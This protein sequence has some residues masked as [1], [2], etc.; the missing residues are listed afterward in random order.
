MFDSDVDAF[1]G[2]YILLNSGSSVTS[3][4]GNI[5]FGGGADPSVEY[6]IGTSNGDPGI[7]LDRATVSAGAGN[8]VMNGKGNPA[9]GEGIYLYGNDDAG[10]ANAAFAKIITNSGNITLKGVGNNVRGI[11]LYHAN[12]L[13]GS[14]S[15]N[16]DITAS[17]VA[18]SGGTDL[19]M[20]WLSGAGTAP[21]I[22]AGGSGTLTINALDGA[23]GQ[24]GA[25]IQAAD[26]DLTLNA[27]TM[28]QS[29]GGRVS[30]SGAGNIILTERSGGA[31]FGSG[32]GGVWATGTG[33]ITITSTAVDLNTANAD[34]VLQGNAQLTIKP[35]SAAS[36]IGVGDAAAGTLNLT[37]AE[38]SELKNG[39]SAITIGS[40]A[41]GD[42][43]VGATTLS[44]N[45]PLTL[46]T[47]GS[48]LF[49]AN[50]VLTGNNN[51]L[52]VWSDAD[53]NS[54][55]YIRLGNG[56]SINTGGGHLWMGGGAVSGSLWNGLT[57]G[58]S[59]A[60]GNGTL[61][62]GIHFD[63]STLATGGGNIAMYGKSRNGVSA[64]DDA[65]HTQGIYLGDNGS[66]TINSGA[67]TILM[68]G[69][70]RGTNNW[71][72]GIE[73]SSL[74]GAVHT[75]T[76][77]ATSGDAIT[78]IGDGS[79]SSS[80]NSSVGL[81]FHPDTT[82][83]A[84]GG[85]NIN[86]T[87]IGGTVGTNQ[88]AIYA[89]GAAAINSGNGNLT[90]LG[91]GAVNMDAA[92]LTAGGTTSLTAENVAQTV[93][94]DISA[95]NVL[96]D[97]GGAVS[98]SAAAGVSLIDKNA[99]SLGAITAT[100]ML[101]I[102]SLT[103]DLTLTGNISTTNATA[104]AVKL[105]A[106]KTAAA[107]TSTGGNII[108][109]GSPS[110]TT[111]D[112]GRVTMYSGSEEGSAGLT[113]LL[114]SGSGRFRYNSDEDTA[115]F[116][117][118]LGSGKYAIYREQP[119]V[120]VSAADDSMTYSGS[121]YSGG[122]G[123]SYYGFK[124]G[125][126]ASSLSGVVSYGGTSQGAVDTGTYAITPGGLSNGLGYALSYLN[127]TLLIGENDSIEEIVTGL[128]SL[129]RS[130][131]GTQ[132]DPQSSGPLFGALSIGP[133]AGSDSLIRFFDFLPLS[134]SILPPDY[135]RSRRIM[136]THI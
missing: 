130:T 52:V 120:N 85:G 112:G 59:F 55:G 19:E 39:F 122:N 45:D 67:G 38:F 73:F 49:N 11:Y 109:S 128:T 99:M 86:I 36:T 24:N 64:G 62:N 104:S 3:N 72:I 57:V 47:A 43:N 53:A 44:Y 81:W 94:Y 124:N 69:V 68:H 82:I 119:S 129:Q 61:S 83:S 31:S 27:E 116:T 6:A 92:V 132:T 10:D 77:A 46:K 115:N 33:A 7:K 26:G 42:I 117:T 51:S 56:S 80:A 21:T 28:W 70:T 88:E 60:V 96:N 93:K 127:G 89:Q 40:N 41:A 30:T 95:V 37:T 111:G 32:G 4:G 79:A 131:N 65:Q 16:I 136:V 91:R 34:Y 78:I 135:F 13:I 20:H 48:V 126:T 76:S 106:G 1:I 71:A 58:D 113:A 87:G 123:V 110:I 22:S 125:D 50:A 2:G 23:I 15:G 84:T 5:T 100:G 133:G 107:G 101:D 97:F 102:A 9:N 121:A 8:I 25:Y 134:G 12:S 75:I 18:G 63:G 29:F 103:Y 105:N 17:M 74:S 118:A 108:V 66:S 114:V 14:D 35:Y 54:D 98:V 90:L